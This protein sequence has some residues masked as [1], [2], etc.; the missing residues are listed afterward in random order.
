M[1]RTFHLGD[2][3]VTFRATGATIRLYR[4]IFQRDIL[5][6]MTRIQKEAVDGE[7]TPEALGFLENVAYTMAKQADPDIPDTADEWL[8][9]FDMFSLYQIFPEIIKLWGTSTAT[10]SE[11][12]KKALAQT[13]R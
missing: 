12:K 13:D 10:L 5:Q 1:E 3:P 6:D 7:V 4:Q 9:Q 11:S 8:D 2:K